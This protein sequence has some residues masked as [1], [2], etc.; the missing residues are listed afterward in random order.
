MMTGRPRGEEEGDDDERE[1]GGAKHQ[2]TDTRIQPKVE[3]CPVNHASPKA[4]VAHSLEKNFQS[5]SS[6]AAGAQSAIRGVAHSNSC[7][8]SFSLGGQMIHNHSSALRKRMALA[9]RAPCINDLPPAIGRV[10][11]SSSHRVTPGSSHRASSQRAIESRVAEGRGFRERKL[12]M[13]QLLT[14]SSAKA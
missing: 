5:S 14:R 4:Q 7:T 1:G 9:P 8:S 3:V 12:S 10:I 2:I 13:L 11:E 6:L